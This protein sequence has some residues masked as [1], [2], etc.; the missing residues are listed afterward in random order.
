MHKSGVIAPNPPKYLCI[1]SYIILG[2][3][4]NIKAIILLIDYYINTA[5]GE[6]IEVNK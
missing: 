6:Y 1:L 4:L 2:I 3:R 5:G